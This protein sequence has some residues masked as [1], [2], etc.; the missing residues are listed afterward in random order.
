MDEFDVVVLGTGAAGLT[1]AIRAAEDGAKVGV[2]EKGD[3]VGGTSAWSGGMIWIPN[4][5]HMAELGIHDCAEESLAYIMSLSHGMIEEDLARAF[6]D[7]GPEMVRWM[8]AN[9]PAQFRIVEGFPDYHPEFP[10]GKTEGGRSMECPLF[11][12]R[13]LGE[14]ADRIT[15]SYFFTMPLTMAES[16]IGGG[17]YGEVSAEE[18]QRRIDAQEWGCGHSL[19]G[20][21]LKGCLDR[22]IEPVSNARAVE[23]VMENG[24]VAGVKFEG[25][26][27]PFQVRVRAGVV[28]ATG[29]FE[30]N[31]DMVKSFLRGPMT[32]PVSIPTNTGDGL[33]MSMRAGASLGNMREAWWMPAVEIPGDR[34]DGRPMQ[35]IFQGERSRPGAIMVNRTGKRFVSEASNYNAFGS[36]FHVQD[37]AKFTY[38][39]LPCWSICDQACVD[40][41]GFI[42][43]APG[44]PV[45]D[46]VMKADTLRE[47]AEKLGVPGDVLEETVTRWNAHVNAGHDPDFG[48]GDSAQDNWWG[49]ATKRGR[50]SATLGTLEKGPF[51]AVE[52][53]SG[54]LGTKGGPKTDTDARVLDLDG[55][56]IPGLYA[57]GNVMASAMGM[58][59]GGAGGT[60][61]PGMVFGY[62]AGRHAA[63]R[64]R[65][66]VNR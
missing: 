31:P 49:D 52:V 66:L 18:L 21:L 26:D 65:T 9:T 4:N 12:F 60:L 27:G 24:R 3:K 55:A 19:V 11:S 16:T 36:A 20:R 33:K 6:V 14:W 13:E 54:S 2:F 62:L 63:E 1:A 58:T 7:V 23:L 43:T 5:D 38:I 46:W 15:R 10:F 59:Y 51:Y 47:L 57:A 17:V 35:Y 29:G 22:G 61:G 41:Y 8:E 44:Q 25:P 30:W 42:R 56:P 48:R 34:G 37:V 32:S 28:L 64:A 40:H 50:K 39:N 45:L 53:T